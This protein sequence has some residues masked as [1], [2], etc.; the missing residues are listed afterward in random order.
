MDNNKVYKIKHIPTGLFYTPVKGK[1]RNNKTNLSKK[2]KFYPMNKPSFEHI[3]HCIR[4]SNTLLKKYP[5]IS[6]KQSYGENII[7][8]DENDWEIIEYM[9][10]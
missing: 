3:K 9:L 2:G 6:V 5:N 10:S 8:W 7:A 4:I 1:Y